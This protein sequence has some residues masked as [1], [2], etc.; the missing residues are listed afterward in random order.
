MVSYRRQVVVIGA[1][2]I[3]EVLD[4]P[5]CGDRAASIAKSK[6]VSEHPSAAQILKIHTRA[7]P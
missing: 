7:M 5:R 2:N 6:S 4:D 1:T 3:P